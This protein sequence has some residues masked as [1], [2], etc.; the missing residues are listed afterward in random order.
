VKLSICIPTYNAR[1]WIEQCL[2][3]IYTHAASCDFEII[4][5]DDRSTDETVAIVRS[6]FPDV[7]VLTNPANVG[8]S[9]T[10]NVGLRAARGEYLLVLNNDTWI[11]PGA[12]DALVGY[13]DRHQDV[14]IVGPKVVCGDGS[15]QQQCRRRIPT[16]LGALLYFTKLSH[17]F[18]K[19]ARFARYLMTSHDERETFDV[20][21][22]SGA[23]M[24]IR[25]Q[26][27]DQIGLFDEQFFLYG[28]DMDFCWRTKLAGWK[29][30]YHP[31]S[32]IT[33]FGGQGGTGRRRVY[34]T[35]EFHRAM[36]LFYRKHRA[37][38]VWFPE[39][40]LV[41]SGITLKGAI[42]VMV[43]SFH[44]STTPGTAKPQ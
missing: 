44:R 40:A 10:V 33:H 3:S 39:R 21:A 24:L 14:G 2:E 37:P 13:L 7:T 15:L 29:V 17:R 36:W 12:L 6:R 8:F 1:D 19:N 43:N 41:Y 11:H 42:A 23:C 32:V 16:P 30:V 5:I 34:A 4:A 35:I 31:D 27:M 25:R 38:N 20:D 9:K 22:V 26:A 18:A 28:E